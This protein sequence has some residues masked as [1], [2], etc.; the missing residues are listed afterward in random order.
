MRLY[1]MLDRKMKE[2]GPVM[3]SRNDP[4]MFRVLRDSLPPQSNEGRHPED[5]DLYFLGVMSVET[6]VISSSAPLLV[7]T[8]EQVLASVDSSLEGGV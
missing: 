8:L 4:V 5:F 1:A 2:F 3:V 6:G 7:A